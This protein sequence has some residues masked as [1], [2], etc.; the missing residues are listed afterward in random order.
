MVLENKDNSL[1]GSD[2]SYAQCP[3]CHEMYGDDDLLWICCDGCD[4]W[5]HV[6]CTNPT[7]GRDISEEYF[8]QQCTYV[9]V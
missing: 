3:E 1:L 4:T 2:S 9:T 6:N 5:Y 8:C 7:P